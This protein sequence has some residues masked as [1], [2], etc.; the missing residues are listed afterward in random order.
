M[1]K[2]G[3]TL[4]E[5]IA[6]IIIIGVLLMIAI[7]S[8]SGIIFSSRDNVYSNNIAAY[9]NEIDTLYKEKKFGPLLDEDQIMMVPIKDISFEKNNTNDSPYGGYDFERS[10]IIIERSEHGYKLYATVVDT[11]KRG[12][13]ELL[14]DDVNSS[15]I[16]V[17]DTNNFVKISNYFKCTS[18][19]FDY[20]AESFYFRG[21]EYKGYDTY[22]YKNVGC[23]ATPDYYPIIVFE[24]A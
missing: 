15:I 23:N 18:G 3:F 4:L 9:I 7:P 17:Q 12:V 24:K 10:Y 2:K 6:V 14:S 16:K 11:T 21:T 20:T 8:V 22:N 19:K 5:L 13:F 1:N